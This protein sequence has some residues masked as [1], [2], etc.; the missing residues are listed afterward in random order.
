MKRAGASLR[1]RGV[2]LDQIPEPE[3]T[4][5]PLWNDGLGSKFDQS[6]SE[7]DAQ[8]TA[9]EQNVSGPLRSMCSKTEVQPW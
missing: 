1:F 3:A 8:A 2:P 5:E 6:G 7:V 9:G 4:V